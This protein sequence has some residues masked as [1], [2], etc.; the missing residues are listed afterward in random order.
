MAHEKVALSNQSRKYTRLSFAHSYFAVEVVAIHKG[1]SVKKII[2]GGFVD[3]FLGELP[4]GEE[5]FD[6]F[7]AFV[8]GVLGKTYICRV[9]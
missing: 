4:L 8:K 3:G 5:L 6:Y 9:D 1:E 2:Y 7:I